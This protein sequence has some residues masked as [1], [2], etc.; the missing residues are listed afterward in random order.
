VRGVLTYFD[1]QLQRIIGAARQVA[2]K[3]QYDVLLFSQ[4][5]E[6]FD[7]DEFTDFQ[8]HRIKSVAFTSSIQQLS[9]V[10][11]TFDVAIM[12]NHVAPSDLAALFEMRK[13]NL[14]DFFFVWTFDNHHHRDANMIVNALADVIIPSHKFCANY[15]RSPCTI[16]GA[17]VP[18]GTNQ[19]SRAKARVLYAASMRLARR[20]G[21]HGGFVTWWDEDR[22][23]LAAECRARLPENAI[24]LI[25]RNERHSYFGLSAEDRWHEWASHKVELVLPLTCDLSFRL[26]DSLLVGQVPLVPTWCKDLD[27]VIPVEMQEALPVI[28]FGTATA[29]AVEIAWREAIRRFDAGGEAGMRRRHLYALEN[30]HVVNRLKAICSQID[31]VATPK[32][33]PCTVDDEGVGF[34]L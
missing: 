28:R 1:V 5:P 13:E 7:T 30:H 2:T 21:L 8:D 18:L 34:V 14:A 19:W 23:K 12:C 29:E 9:T 27:D 22:I 24:R 16:L 6:Y 4:R 26:F 10:G 31:D 11:R 3:K 33:I 20:D 25:D 17:H 32:N 15:M